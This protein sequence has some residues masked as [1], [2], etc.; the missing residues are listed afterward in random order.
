MRG[1][2][3]NV[4]I[5][6]A[7]T[8]AL[9]LAGPALAAD[10]PVAKA[11]V[12]KAAAPPPSPIYQLAFGLS[13]SNDY[14]FRG[15]SQ[16]NRDWSFGGYAEGRYNS[17]YGQWYL[18]VAGWRIDWPGLSTPY[19]FTDPSA[20]VDFFGGW[21]HTW[22]KASVDIGLIYY[23]YPGE[24]FNGFTSDSDFWEIYW[25][26]GYAVSDT[27]SVG[28]NLFYSPDVLNY[29]ETFASAAYGGFS[30]KASGIY[31]SLTAAYTFWQKD[32]WKSV[33]SGELGHWWL[34]GTG[35][36][37]GGYVDPDYTYWN[38]GLAFTYKTVTLDLR[39]HGTNQSVAQCTSFLLSAVGNPSNKW[40]NDAYIATLK[41]DMTLPN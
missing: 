37:A 15:V 18:G 5:F 22:D 4:A 40:C 39:Y 29:S 35:F 17:P 38:A 10:A 3:S 14:N 6:G 2:S 8:L 41:F 23:Y 11:P 34:K 28:A 36:T 30:A 24:T 21:R 27:L 7:A 19:G 33:V 25:K 32:D 9:S 13:V 12:M 16:S 31:G 20:E 26:G 1:K